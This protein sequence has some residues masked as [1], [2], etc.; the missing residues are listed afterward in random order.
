MRV[1]ARYDT[2]RE[3]RVGQA[4]DRIARV[5]ALVGLLLVVTSCRGEGAAREVY[6]EL[7]REQLLADAAAI[8]ATYGP[9]ADVPA[10]SW[11][12]SFQRFAPKRVSTNA[13]GVYI[14]TH[15]RLVESAGVFLRTDTA[16]EPPESGDPGFEQIDTDVYWFYAPG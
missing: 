10:A 6:A 9:S 12:A 11:P 16:Y 14:S 5:I 3:Q 13:H 15:Q 4:G 8:H 2:P 7:S 1:A